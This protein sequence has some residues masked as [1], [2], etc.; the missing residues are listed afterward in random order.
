VKELILIAANVATTHLYAPGAR[1]HMQNALKL[2]ATREEILEV[3]ELVSVLGIHAANMG[4]PILAELL[5]KAKPSR[6][7]IRR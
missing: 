3:I 1:R 4:V 6:R 2:G 7:R 5:A